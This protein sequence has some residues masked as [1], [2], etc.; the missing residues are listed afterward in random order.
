MMQDYTSIVFTLD[1]SGHCLYDEVIDLKQL[2]SLSMQRASHVEFNERKQLWEVLSPDR[3]QVYFQS[4]SRQ[5]CLDW[6]R[7]NLPLPV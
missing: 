6:E 2:G 5:Q 7:N 4:R 1:G 3:Q